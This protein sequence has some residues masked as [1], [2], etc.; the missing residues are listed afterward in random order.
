MIYQASLL[1]GTGIPVTQDIIH[2]LNKGRNR[3]LKPDIL[4]PMGKHKVSIN[5]L[6][7]LLKNVH[8][9]VHGITY[10]DVYPIDRMYYR[11]FEKI[12]KSRVIDALQQNVPQS[13]AT[14]QY[15]LIFRDVGDSFL[16]FDLSP[17]D[18]IHLIMRSTYFVRIWRRFIQTSRSYNLKD[19][20]ITYNAYMCIEIN[21][22]YLVHLIKKFRDHA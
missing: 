17:L 6:K 10:S 18:R 12:M 16:K 4:L 7:F 9:S 2:L 13:E 21:A 11:S 5:D 3:L 22:K 1:Y 19:N 20:F 15:L 8:K 14:L